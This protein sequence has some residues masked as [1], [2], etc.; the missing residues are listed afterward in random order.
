MRQEG[1]NAWLVSDSSETCFCGNAAK[2]LWENDSGGKQSF[3]GDQLQGDALV[4][5]Q[6]CMPS[7][8]P[9]R[10]ALCSLTAAWSPEVGGV[11]PSDPS[12]CERLTT[13]K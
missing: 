10:A 9:C 13:A 3:A 8:S 12:R 4:R 6:A 7:C 1:S 11:G 2:V 5:A